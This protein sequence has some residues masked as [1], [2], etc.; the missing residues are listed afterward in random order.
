MTKVWPEL[1]ELS[2]ALLE[3][4]R[5]DSSYQSYLERQEADVASFKR[6]ENVELLHNIDF[7]R[8]PGLS[9][10]MAD[11]L[12]LARPATLGAAGR[13]PGITPAA[14]IALLPFTR[15]AA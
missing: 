4:L 13:I 3:S 12:A 7:R 11:R 6:D 14:L 2:A 8:V 5:V 9:H 1:G 15:R 10:E